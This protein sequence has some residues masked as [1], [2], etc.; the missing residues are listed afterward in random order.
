MSSL[1]V[2][3]LI[4]EGV[5]RMMTPGGI[6]IPTPVKMVIP[7]L[8]F[9]LGLSGS[10]HLLDGPTSLL[11]PT[12]MNGR[13]M[14]RDTLQPSVKNDRKFL[15]QVRKTHLN[16][17]G[18]NQP[19]CQRRILLR[20]GTRIQSTLDG[21]GPSLAQRAISRPDISLLI[22][23]CSLPTAAF[24]LNAVDIQTAT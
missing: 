10:V 6:G 23:R 14:Q 19:V 22:L 21:N 12:V 2:S 20:N 11:P 7:L 18:P 16:H 8:L 5:T 9:G 3:S 13:L 17:D 4:P 15:L 24:R 1:S